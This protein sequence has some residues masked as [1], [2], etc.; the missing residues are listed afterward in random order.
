MGAESLPGSTRPLGFFDPLGLSA[1]K[2]AATLAYWRES[3]LKHGRLAMLA[4]LGI[5]VGEGVEFSTPLF[6]DKIVG[7]AIYQFQEADQLTGFSFAFGIIS[8]IAAIETVGIKKGWETAEQKAARDPK[9]KTRS[10]IL[11]DYINGDL[12]F[13]PLGFKPADPAAFAT[14]QTKELNNGRLAMLSVAGMLAQELVNGK[15]I[16]ENIGL[17]SALPAAFDTGVL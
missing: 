3:E 13:D 6:G 9:G 5:I 15:G 2:D 10:Q 12:G 4:A 1:G 14:I 17:E 8:L 7:P 11:P 16:L